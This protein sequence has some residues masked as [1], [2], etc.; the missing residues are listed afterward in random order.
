MAAMSTRSMAS[1]LRVR[2]VPGSRPPG[3]ASKA[4]RCSSQIQTHLA[5]DQSAQGAFPTGRDPLPVL[6]LDGDEQVQ[7]EPELPG[8][9]LLRHALGHPGQT[10]QFAQTCL[11]EL[12]RHGFHPTGNFPEGAPQLLPAFIAVEAPIVHGAPVR[13]GIAEGVLEIVR[14]HEG[15]AVQPGLGLG[16]GQPVARWPGWNRSHRPSGRG[17]PRVRCSPAPPPTDGCRF[18]EART[19]RHPASSR[20]GPSSSSLSLPASPFSTRR[21]A[22]GLG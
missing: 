22:S 11:F 17:P 8:Q 15:P 19:A 20:E 12:C 10:K 6:R 9:A 16:Q 4:S 2:G 1:R 18:T 7:G 3:R 13:Q 14:G 5:R 21:S